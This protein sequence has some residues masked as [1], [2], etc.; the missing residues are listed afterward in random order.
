MKFENY[1]TKYYSNDF[2][3]NINFIYKKRFTIKGNLKKDNRT[4]FKDIDSINDKLTKKDSKDVDSFGYM[5]EE[6]LNNED[7]LKYTQYVSDIDEKK[8]ED[9]D[10]ESEKLI[11]K[12]KKYKYLKKNSHESNK[13]NKNIYKNFTKQISLDINLLRSLGSPKKMK[14]ILRTQKSEDYNS[15]RFSEMN[16]SNDS[17][18]D[19][20]ENSIIQLKK[21]ENDNNGENIFEVNL[22][23]EQIKFEKNIDELQNNKRF[24]KYKSYESHN[25]KKESKKDF[26]FGEF[27]KNYSTKNM[28]ETKNEKKSSK[29]NVKITNENK[30]D[31]DKNDDENFDSEKDDEIEEINNKN[32]KIVDRNS[33]KKFT[34]SEKILFENDNVINEEKVIKT[35]KNEKDK[36]ENKA[37]FSIFMENSKKF[38]F[39][40]TQDYVNK[41]ETNNNNDNNNDN[42]NENKNNNENNNNDNKNNNN[43]DNNNNVNNNNNNNNENNNNDN[44]NNEN[45]NNDNKKKLFKKKSSLKKTNYNNNNNTTNDNNKNLKKIPNLSSTELLITINTS[46]LNK[47]K[48]KKLSFKSDNIDNNNNHNEKNKKLSFSD[49]IEINNEKNKKSSKKLIFDDNFLNEDNNENNNNESNKNVHENFIEKQSEKEFRKLSRKTSEKILNKINSIK[50]PSSKIV[51]KL[52]YNNLI[53]DNNDLESSQNQEKNIFQFEDTFSSNSEYSNNSIKNNLLNKNN[54]N[55]NENNNNNH[56]NNLNNHEKIQSLE[57]I[58]KLKNLDLNLI[59]EEDILS[60]QIFKKSILRNNFND[61]ESI[62]T[63]SNGDFFNYPNYNYLNKIDLHSKTHHSNFFKNIKSNNN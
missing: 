55:S 62:S 14:K 28:I 36:N 7:F 40:L 29:K 18:E 48:G 3:H 43:T 8:N 35:D 37:N 38:T 19:F 54:F 16:D 23:K 32:K 5:N 1:L 6:K 30:I 44:N 31:D 20:K 21:I 42:K 26:N 46:E 24:N 10:S 17:I 52:N 61:S 58:N 41:V 25:E 50:K 11:L 33:M 63:N 22:N 49:N 45:N 12:T 56:N 4:S 15:I 59:N 2:Y 13:T 39:K 51:H 53:F 34:F 47:K 9:N 27:L 57:F 60:N